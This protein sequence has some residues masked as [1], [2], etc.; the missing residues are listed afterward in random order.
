MNQILAIFSFAVLRV[1]IGDDG[2]L[3]QFYPL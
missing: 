3:M 2:L 1:F